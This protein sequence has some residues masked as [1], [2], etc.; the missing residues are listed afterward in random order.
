M[1]LKFVIGAFV[2]LPTNS[3]TCKL[4]LYCPGVQCICVVFVG[5]ASELCVC[6]YVDESYSI[7]CFITSVIVVEL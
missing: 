1:Q 3:H 5:L 6:L 2:G 7:L 4:S